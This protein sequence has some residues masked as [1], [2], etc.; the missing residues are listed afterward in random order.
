MKVVAQYR[1]SRDNKRWRDSHKSVFTVKH[2]LQTVMKLHKVRVWLR[3]AHLQEI[4]SEP[5]YGSQETEEK[6][7]TT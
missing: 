5:T 6:S 3:E 7:V 4:W 2:N 1:W